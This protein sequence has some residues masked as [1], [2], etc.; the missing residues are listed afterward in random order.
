MELRLNITEELNGIVY[1]CQATNEALKRSV[2][3]AITLQV[4]CKLYKIFINFSRLKLD[5][6]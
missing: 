1:T 2:H 5:F 3:D 6:L 4:L